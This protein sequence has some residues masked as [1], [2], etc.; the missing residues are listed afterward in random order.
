MYL[1]TGDFTIEM[2]LYTT[3]AT[4]VQQ[5]FIRRSSAAAR[6]MLMNIGGV[7][8]QKITFL[9][10]DTNTA[11]WEVSLTSGTSLASN[12]WYHVAVTRNGNNFT[13][14]LNGVSEATASSSVT[15]ADDTSNFL[16]GV[17]DGASNYLNGYLDDF[18]VTKGVARYLTSFTPPPARMPGQ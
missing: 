3:T 5:I 13:L 10:G 9:A 2:W 8:S 1:S 11:A 14:W 18:R 15:I 17:S 12:T 7:T 16:I 6:G 4:T